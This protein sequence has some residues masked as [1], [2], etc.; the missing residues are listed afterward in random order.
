MSI[1]KLGFTKKL[2]RQLVTFAL[3][4]A[5][6]MGT[7]FGGGISYATD[8]FPV[9]EYKDVSNGKG[10]VKFPVKTYEYSPTTKWRV[11]ST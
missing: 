2:R 9:I 8:A 5:I 6:T 4:G 10:S 3:A 11:L 7:L 1:K